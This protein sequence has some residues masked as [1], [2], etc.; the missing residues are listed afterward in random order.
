MQH[1]GELSALAIAL[2]TLIMAP[3]LIFNFVSGLLPRISIAGAV[4]CCVIAVIT[5][6][7]VLQIAW[8]IEGDG[9]FWLATYGVLM[10][11]LAGLG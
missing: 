7:N 3:V 10:L 8:F 6:R 5:N 11:G 9:R 4:A 2:A 1:N